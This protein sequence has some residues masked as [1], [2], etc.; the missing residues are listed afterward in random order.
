MSKNTDRLKARITDLELQLE[1]RTAG[2]KMWKAR[3]LGLHETLNSLSSKHFQA[4][5]ALNEAYASMRDRLTA[6]RETEEKMLST[7]KEE[8]K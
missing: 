6:L 1:Q 5:M 7:L 2:E 4:T 3:A 8:W